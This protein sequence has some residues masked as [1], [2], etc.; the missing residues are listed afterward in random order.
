MNIHFLNTQA[1]TWA[2]KHCVPHQ[3]TL[4][5]LLV[6][7]T[8]CWII[9]ARTPTVF[10]HVIHF[11]DQRGMDKLP[12]MIRNRLSKLYTTDTVRTV[13]IAAL[14]LH[15]ATVQDG[16]IHSGDLLPGHTHHTV[17]L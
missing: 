6:R 9:H 15:N 16:V 12:E 1:Y 13:R 14:S 5:V 8:K 17:T 10:G 11:T 2:W 7:S 3:H 4:T